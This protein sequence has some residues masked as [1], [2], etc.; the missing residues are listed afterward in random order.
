MTC[1]ASPIWKSAIVSVKVPPTSHQ[2]RIGV[3]IH[4][5]EFAKSHIP[6]QLPPSWECT[7]GVIDA[8]SK[9]HLRDSIKHRSVHC[10][11]HRL[12]FPSQVEEGTTDSHDRE[13]LYGDNRSIKN[14]PGIHELSV[15]L[16]V[17]VT[18]TVCVVSV[19]TDGFTVTL[20]GLTPAAANMPR[21]LFPLQ[22]C[23]TLDNSNSRCL[24]GCL[25]QQCLA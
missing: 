2:I 25:V 14:R 3:F 19:K 22:R 23:R 8:I 9:Q 4:R 1:R 18:V 20:S 10:R 15:T 11:C 21:A 24:I 17:T 12:E 16:H 13:S 7:T 6:E 5:V